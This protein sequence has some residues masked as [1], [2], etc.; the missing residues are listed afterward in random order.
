MRSLSSRDDG[1]FGYLPNKA[2]TLQLEFSSVNSL[3]KVRVLWTACIAL[4]ISAAVGLRWGAKISIALLPAPQRAF[5]DAELLHSIWIKR[6]VF[7]F[8]TCAVCGILGIYYSLRAS[9]ASER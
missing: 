7:L 2:I 1:V 4:F 6:S 9:D 5:A 3:T 8:L